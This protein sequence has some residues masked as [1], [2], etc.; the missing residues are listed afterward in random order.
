MTLRRLAPA[1]LALAVLVPT[2]AYAQR[3]FGRS[4]RGPAMTAFGPVYNP[5]MSPEWR[6]AGGNPVVYEQIMH[7]KMM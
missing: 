1:L 4:H 3:G 6:M 7:M 5:T 2:S